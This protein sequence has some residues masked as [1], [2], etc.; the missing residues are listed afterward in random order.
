MLL[1]CLF[2]LI[3]WATAKNLVALGRTLVAQPPLLTV[4][5]VAAL[6]LLG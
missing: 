6:A 2:L 3:G 4:A 1:G 5:T